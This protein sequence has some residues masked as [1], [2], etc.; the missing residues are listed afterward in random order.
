MQ[1]LTENKTQNE[2]DVIAGKSRVSNTDTQ[3]PVL[4]ADQKIDL[5]KLTCQMIDIRYACATL[6]LNYLGHLID[7]AITEA[8]LIAEPFTPNSSGNIS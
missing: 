2:I 3:N 5:N 1:A 4:T 7:M 6:Q 8:E